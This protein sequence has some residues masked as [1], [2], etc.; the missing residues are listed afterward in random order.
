MIIKIKVIERDPKTKHSFSKKIIQRDLKE[1]LQIKNIQKLPLKSSRKRFTTLISPH[2]HK[3]AQTSFQT[4][5]HKY[6]L[7]IKAYELFKVLTYLKKI[8]Y[9]IVPDIRI[10]ITFKI[11]TRP[12]ISIS[13][14]TI[15]RIQKI[16]Q[17][18]PILQYIKEL[19]F[20]GKKFIHKN[21]V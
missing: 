4:T 14:D 19:G 9:K 18:Q 12:K 13:K 11:L 8:S 20:L 6:L 17:R 21:S 16:N 7:K 5:H 2:A 3:D 1:I 15:N 10:K